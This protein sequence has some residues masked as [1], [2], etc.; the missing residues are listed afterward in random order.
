MPI[1]VIY[2]SEDIVIVQ[3]N[4]G[5][6]LLADAKDK[7]ADEKKSVDTSYGA[8]NLGLHVQDNPALVLSHRAELLTML[9]QLGR[10]DNIYWLNQVHGNHVYDVDNHDIGLCVPDADA[11]LSQ[12]AHCAL[13]IMTADCVPICVWQPASQKIAVIHAGWQGLAKGIIAQTLAQFN[14]TEGQVCAMIG[15]CISQH[16][17][18]VSLSVV[19]QLNLSQYRLDNQASESSILVQPHHSDAQKAW[20]NLPAI[21]GVQLQSAGVE[22]LGTHLPVEQDTQ[23]PTDHLVASPE[24]ACSYTDDRYYSYRRMTHHQQQQTGRMAMLIMR[25]S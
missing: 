8:F 24:W 3:T 22:L 19:E 6:H 10:V 5:L 14:Q 21:A 18:E 25:L 7:S 16:C 13:A 11:M 2:Q 20:V 17:Y 9:N 23:A 12:Q 15:A 4:A 1:E